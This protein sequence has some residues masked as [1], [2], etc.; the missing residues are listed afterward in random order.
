M[1][2][3]DRKKI[4]P[5]ILKIYDDDFKEIMKLIPRFT[6]LE[7]NKGYNFQKIYKK[8]MDLNELNC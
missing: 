8:A 3:L 5:D 6:A 7:E 2:I 4:R 1:T